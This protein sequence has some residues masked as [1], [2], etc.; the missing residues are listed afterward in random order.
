MG[1][2]NGSFRGVR[3]VGAGATHNA[4][5][6]WG[7][8]DTQR[9]VYPPANPDRSSALRSEIRVDYVVVG[10]GGGGGGAQPPNKGKGG[11]GGGGGVLQGTTIAQTGTSYGITVGT[12]GGGGPGSSPGGRGN[13]SNFGPI[14]AYGGGG[15][16]AYSTQPVYSKYGGSGGGSNNIDSTNEERQGI[17]KQ[18]NPGGNLLI[19]AFGPQQQKASAGGGG[20]GGRGEDSLSS[21]GGNGG[22]AVLTR[23]TGSDAWYGGGGGGSAAFPYHSS[24]GSG[25]DHPTITTST[26]SILYV[27][28]NQGSISYVGGEGHALRISRFNTSPVSGT[29]GHAPGSLGYYVDVYSDATNVSFSVED[30]YLRASGLT[31]PNNSITFN[32]SQ[33]NSTVQSTLQPY[34]NTYYNR[35]HKVD[36]RMS[37]PS[38]PSQ[39]TYVR[40]WSISLSGSAD[41]YVGG[42][43]AICPPSDGM[44]GS[45][46]TFNTGGGG[47]GGA[48][49]DESPGPSPN[50]HAYPGGSGGPGIIILRYPNGFTINVPSAIDH[51]PVTP[52]PGT[53]EQY[54]KLL[55]GSGSV[56]WS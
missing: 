30:T 28:D 25:G 32:N 39:A 7:L 33:S 11:G 6:I 56:S 55:K 44:L 37:T 23:I 35:R 42:P 27:T 1:R 40:S 14:E 15:G 36:F 5:G 46:G 51:G 20:A 3:N 18:G 19:N 34:D 53:N 12:G 54:I 10:G 48:T 13:N 16:Q 31:A 26:P 4:S 41:Y 38:Y 24:V 49:L 52:I 29:E 47:G 43:G 21:R 17:H 22:N 8:N 9:Y 50:Y 45:P 2:K